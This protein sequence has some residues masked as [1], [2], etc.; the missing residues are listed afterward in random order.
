[1]LRRRLLFDNAVTGIRLPN[2]LFCLDFEDTATNNL[3][4]VTDTVSGVP[5]N[6]AGGTANSIDFINTAYGR[7]IRSNSNTPLWFQRN[8]TDFPRLYNFPRRNFSLVFWANAVGNNSYRSGILANYNN[9]Q[10]IGYQGYN[11]NFDYSGLSITSGDF[12]IRPWGPANSFS[13]INLWVIS[14]NEDTQRV[15]GCVEWG[16]EMLDRGVVSGM[17]NALNT[18]TLVFMRAQESSYFFRNGGLMAGLTIYDDVL[19]T[20]HVQHIFDN[21][22]I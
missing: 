6:V 1:M 16:S 9:Y 19:T 13:N 8:F 10:I 14:Y 20:Q 12:G 3:S 17:T 22:I 11:N 7:T 18:G 4:Q 21:K 2:K 5:L 15:Y